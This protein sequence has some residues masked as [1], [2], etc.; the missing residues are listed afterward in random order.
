LSIY[1][2][3]SVINMTDC[4]LVNPGSTPAVTH[5]LFLTLVP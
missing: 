5:I 3:S 2:D 1:T 4:H